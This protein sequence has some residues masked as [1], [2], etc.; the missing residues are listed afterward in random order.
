MIKSSAK[1]LND[2]EIDMHVGDIKSER[3]RDRFHHQDLFELAL[4]IPSGEA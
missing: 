4:N 1:L 3:K 2:E